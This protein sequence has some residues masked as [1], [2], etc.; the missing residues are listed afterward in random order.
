M[1][2][3]LRIVGSIIGCLC[4][5]PAG[6]AQ[7]KKAPASGQEK[8]IKV[9]AA[10]QTQ[11]LFRMTDTSWVYYVPYGHVDISAT[12]YTSVPLDCSQG[13]VAISASWTATSPNPKI[14]VIENSRINDSRWQVTF[15]NADQN[16]DV[17]IDVG[18]MCFGNG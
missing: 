4:L 8:K 9:L 18:V 14:L 2:A 11:K 6:S 17:R 15:A 12:D 7:E 5:V 13:G 3:S 16:N 1:R 10:G